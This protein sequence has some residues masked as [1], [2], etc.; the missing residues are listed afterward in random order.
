MSPF[1]IAA[2]VVV[3]VAAALGAVVPMIL[4]RS[5]A[6]AELPDLVHCLQFDLQRYR[7]MERL[8]TRDDLVFLSSVP[9]FDLRRVGALRAERKRIF[10]RYLQ[11]LETDFSQMHLLARMLLVASQEDRPE[12]A[13][14][15]MRQQ[16]AFRK[17]ALRIRLR[18]WMPGFRVAEREL[19]KAFGLLEQTHAELG[20]VRELAASRAA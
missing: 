2:V 1:F 10:S 14:E 18:L 5:Q 20:R 19:S 13:S 4:R 12:L 17:A 9:G 11:N 15:L 3:A 16:W 7:P 6:S 8:A